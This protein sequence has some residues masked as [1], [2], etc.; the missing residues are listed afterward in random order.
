MKYD[1]FIFVFELL[2]LIRQEQLKNKIS[3]PLWCTRHITFCYRVNIDILIIFFVLY[4]VCFFFNLFVFSSSVCFYIP[5]NYKFC[6][7]H[8]FFSASLKQYCVRTIFIYLRLNVCQ[9]YAFIFSNHE[10]IEKSNHI[11]NFTRK[12]RM[13][14]ILILKQSFILSPK[15]D[16][17]I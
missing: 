1:R 4:E 11:A 10:I 7:S 16:K 15:L 13:V 17:L 2:W 9:F 8:W 3:L 12:E 5:S 6:I 14:T